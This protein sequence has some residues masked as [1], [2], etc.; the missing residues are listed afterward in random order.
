MSKF[1][2]L[3]LLIILLDLIITVVGVKL[4]VLIEL[5]PL[6][7]Y[8]LSHSITLFVCVKLLVQGIGIKILDEH[9]MK[10]KNGYKYYIAVIVVYVL[11][12]ALSFLASYIYFEY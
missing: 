3:L 5:N 8:F 9:L 11:I 12:F 6:M 1:A 4:G 7:Y 10:T 2:K